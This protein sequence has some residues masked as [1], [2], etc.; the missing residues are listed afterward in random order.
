MAFLT[1]L[2][3][4]RFADFFVPEEREDIVRDI[5]VEARRR[6][7]R[8]A[9]RKLVRVVDGEQRIVEDPPFRVR[10]DDPDERAGDDAIVEAYRARGGLSRA[11]RAGSEAR[12]LWDRARLDLRLGNR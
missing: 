12:V 11:D 4:L 8:G 5:R 3:G 7:S 6:T 1:F 10:L 9:A 2:V